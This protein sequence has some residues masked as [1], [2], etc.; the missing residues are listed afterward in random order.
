MQVQDVMTRAVLS[1]ARDT[2]VE[3]AAQLLILRRITGAPVMGSDGAPVG[4]VSLVDLV[5]QRGSTMRVGDLIRRPAVTI[6]A[7]DEIEQAAA[8]MLEH[9]VR[10]L[11]VLDGEH[12]LIGIVSATDLLRGMVRELG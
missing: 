12:R 9:D 11:P 7:L 8:Q 5:A 1:F 4:I 2:R 10:R 3:D 6:G